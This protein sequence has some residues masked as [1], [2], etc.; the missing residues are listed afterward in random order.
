MSYNFAKRIQASASNDDAAKILKWLSRSL[1][2][3]STVP[4]GWNQGG[5]EG[6]A[7]WEEPISV[8]G[9]T[10]K[11]VRFA[12]NAGYISLDMEVDGPHGADFKFST[13]ADSADGLV[14]RFMGDIKN[15]IQTSDYKRRDAAAEFQ[16]FTQLLS[17][18]GGAT[19]DT[20]EQV[21]QQE[22]PGAAQE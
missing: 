1:G 2:R 10:I 19:G 4:Q 20:P 14:Q 11:H 3:P 9:I 17:K 7:E 22:E 18:L 15:Q 5:M 16:G 6:A 12:F 13:E 21:Q 8:D